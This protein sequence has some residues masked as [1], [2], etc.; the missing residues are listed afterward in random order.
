MLVNATWF[1]EVVRKNFSMYPSQNGTK[2]IHMFCDSPEKSYVTN[3]Y[4]T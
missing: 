3:K 2:R 1:L 4:V